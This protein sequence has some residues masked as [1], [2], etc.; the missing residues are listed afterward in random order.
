MKRIFALILTVVLV[1]ALISGCSSSKSLD[2][3]GQFSGGT[4]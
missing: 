4:I 2:Q 1:F 3:S